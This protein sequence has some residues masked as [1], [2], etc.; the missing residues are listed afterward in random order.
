MVLM[1]ARH[2][3]RHLKNIHSLCLHSN[4]TEVCCYV[5][6]EVKHMEVK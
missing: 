5:H 6:V 2:C 1:I 4:T 3:A